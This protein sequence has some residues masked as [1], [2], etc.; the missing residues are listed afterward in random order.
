LR[1]TTDIRLICAF[2]PPLSGGEVHD[3]DGA[4][5]AS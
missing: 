3:A 2:N 5:K 1:A 4:Y